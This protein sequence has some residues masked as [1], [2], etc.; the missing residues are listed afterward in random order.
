MCIF[1]SV[2]L[3]PFSGRCAFEEKRISCSPPSSFLPLPFPFALASSIPRF[4]ALFSLPQYRRSLW[5]L[6]SS[7]E[8]KSRRLELTSDEGGSLS[9]S[10]LFLPSL[11]LPLPHL[12]FALSRLK[13]LQLPYR[14]S[15]T[16]RSI[17]LSLEP[18]EC[19]CNHL[20]DTSSLPACP[21]PTA[22]RS[23]PQ[24]DLPC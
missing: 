6:Q 13:L 12:A 9:S 15:F 4:L 21:P 11:S 24:E 3:S 18:L 8:K 20:F 5:K 2:Q 19:C 10:C 22:S 7:S 16:S 1:S 14:L 17:P 23:S